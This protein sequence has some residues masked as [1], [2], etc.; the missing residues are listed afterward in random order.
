MWLEGDLTRLAQVVGNLLTNAAKYTEDGGEIGLTA[1]R[2]GNEVFLRVCDTGIGI[3]PEMLARVF[4][5]FAQVDH[6]LA[7]SQGGLGIGLT[8]VRMLVEMHGGSVT[9]HSGGL[10]RGSEFVVRL[11]VPQSGLAKRRA[12][13]AGPGEA[14]SGG[15]GRVSGRRILVVDDNED[16]AETLATL[17]RVK[18]HE[19]R[20]AYHGPA[21]LEAT[22]DFRP[23]VIVLDIGLPGM[24]GYEVGRRLRELPGMGET[25]LVALTGYGQDEDRR[26]ALEAGFNAH[27]VKPAEIEVL[28]ELLTWSDESAAP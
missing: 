1:E 4:D 17:L 27:L 21:A 25:V 10:D 14:G 18:G 8:L 2:A 19:V 6:S 28:H 13:A 7:R 20:T 12:G 23:Q 5:L 16:S 9:A 11:P 15:A 26:R 3:P 24:D 22:P